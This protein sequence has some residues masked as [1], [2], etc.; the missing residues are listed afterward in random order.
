MLQN[1]KMNRLFFYQQVKY[2]LDSSSLHSPKLSAK[3]NNKKQQQCFKKT[4]NKS[5]KHSDPKQRVHT[6]KQPHNPDLW[7]ICCENMDPSTQQTR[8]LQLTETPTCLSFP[9][10]PNKKS[11]PG[12]T[13]LT[14]ALFSLL[15]NDGKLSQILPRQFGTRHC[16]HEELF[17]F[18]LFNLAIYKFGYHGVKLLLLLLSQV[19]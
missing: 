10:C 15:H 11:L 19:I 3:N 16:L 18:F 4:K 8:S 1:A 2:I 5:H 14:I 6:Q 13:Q 9:C 12:K 17:F 7:F